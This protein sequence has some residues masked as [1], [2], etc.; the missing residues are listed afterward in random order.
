LIPLIT[1]MLGTIYVFELKRVCLMKLS[2]PKMGA[3]NL[4]FVISSWFI[5]VFIS[6]KWPSLSLD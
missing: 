4:M 2:A 1:I 5:T 6:M 3:Y